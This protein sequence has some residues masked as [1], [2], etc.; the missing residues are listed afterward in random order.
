VHDYG[1]GDIPDA[2][3]MLRMAV[4]Y[5]VNTILPCYKDGGKIVFHRKQQTKE[6]TEE[7]MWNLYVPSEFLA[8]TQCD[9]EEVTVTT[10]GKPRIKNIPAEFHVQLPKHATDCLR[11]GKIETGSP[12]H[13]AGGIKFSLRV[14]YSIL[15]RK[16][17]T[18]PW[19]L[20][21]LAK[22]KDESYEKPAGS[23]DITPLFLKA[24]KDSPRGGPPHVPPD[25][26]SSQRSNTQ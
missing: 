17:E 5:F 19:S 25:S 12:V 20:H 3:K 14:V 23:N 26:Q 2:E 16:R 13:L 4:R 9:D 7:R 8:R 22:L 18:N 11:Q 21:C 6:Q 15:Q 24:P 1:V 10:P